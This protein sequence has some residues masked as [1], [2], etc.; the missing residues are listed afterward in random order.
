MRIIAVSV[1]MRTGSGVSPCAATNSA[2]PIFWIEPCGQTSVPYWPSPR[3]YVRNMNAA[4][5]A[6]ARTVAGPR[7]S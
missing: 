6:N 3:G 4:C 5:V 2:E 1:R 7:I